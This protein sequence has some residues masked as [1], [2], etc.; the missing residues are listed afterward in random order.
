M[1][2]SL[3]SVL[4]ELK[5]FEADIQEALEAADTVVETVTKILPLLTFLPEG[6]TVGKDVM[7]VSTLLAFLQKVLETV[8]AA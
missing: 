5:G 2:F 4:S 7:Y 1:A 6:A 3:D 8:E